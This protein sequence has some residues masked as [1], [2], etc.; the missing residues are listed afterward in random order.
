MSGLLYREFCDALPPLRRRGDYALRRAR[1]G[2]EIGLGRHHVRDSQ[3]RCTDRGLV[4]RAF[5]RR[6][7]AMSDL[8]LDVLRQT[9]P[10]T[11]NRAYM[12]VTTVR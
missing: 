1:A 9:H 11:G 10:P 8:T 4:L 6:N 5:D 2:P 3:S 7:L 12:D